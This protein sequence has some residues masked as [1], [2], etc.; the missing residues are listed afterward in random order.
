MEITVEQ[1]E[2]LND[3]EKIVFDIRPETDRAYG[4]IPDSVSVEE[5]ELRANPPSDK[6]KK[7]VV[8]CAKGILS[9]DIAEWLLEQ[10]YDAYSLQGGY[11]EYLRVHMQKQVDDDFCKRVE[12]SLTGKFKKDIFSKF[13][14]AIKEYELIREGDRL[15]LIHI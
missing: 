15:S 6:S 13:Y 10:G 5:D 14:K 11:S 1:F 3:D 7:I 8:Y 2:K 9:I 12:Q 4:F